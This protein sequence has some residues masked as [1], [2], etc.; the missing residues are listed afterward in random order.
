MQKTKAV[1]P[2]YA[3][4]FRC[5]GPACEDSCCAGWQVD[6]DKVTYEKYQ[7]VAPGPLRVLIDAKIAPVPEETDSGIPSVFARIE[8]LPSLACPFHT[9]D[10]LCQIQVE[11]GEEYLSH[12]CA[13]YPRRTLTI[14]NLA[15]KTLAFSC[16]EACRLV[17]LNPACLTPPGPRP[18]TS[19]G[20]IQRTIPPWCPTS[21]LFASLRLV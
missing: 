7:S 1:R 2:E 15:D 6:V 4:R 13:T 17:L 10:R 20:T 19:I 11:L 12:T 5:I 18:I 16:P 21:G 3:D 14:D 8:L 9:A